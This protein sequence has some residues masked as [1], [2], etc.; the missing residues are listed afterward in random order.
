M[1]AWRAALRSAVAKSARGGFSADALVGFRTA[2]FATFGFAAFGV[3]T[4]GFAAFGVASF[5]VATF[6]VARREARFFDADFGSLAMMMNT[7]EEFTLRP[8]VYARLQ[9]SRY[10]LTLA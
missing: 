1:R 2:G 6:G 7:G 8:E 3:A 9:H 10:R 5:G 4:F